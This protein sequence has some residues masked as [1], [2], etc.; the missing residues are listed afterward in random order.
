MAPVGE[1]FSEVS[2]K[3]SWGA[4][5]ATPLLL[6][7][8]TVDVAAQTAASELDLGV[9]AYKNSHYEE[10]IRH[11]Q[12]ATELDPSNIP[13]HMFLATACLS[14]YIPGVE[15]PGNILVAEHAIE[16][17]QQV[18]N[19]DAKLETKINSAKGIAYLY[20]NMKKFDDSR[21]YYQKALGFDAKDPEPY[22]SIGVIDWTQCYQ[23]RMEARARLGLRP[24]ESLNARIPAQRKACQDL[25]AKNARLVEEGIDS[26]SKAIDLRPDYD[27]AMAY[28]NLMFREKADLECDDRVGRAQDLKTADEWVDKTLAVK[29]AKAEKENRQPRL[30]Y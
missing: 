10:A 19:S 5:I 16:Q 7:S 22:Y 11:F 18:L 17:Y 14:Q 21:E 24:D 23:P 25:G 3:R 13:A 30:R 8:F 4:I 1:L 2:M 9:A 29:R 28:M 15:E 26:L 12:K 6:L 27:D 20:L